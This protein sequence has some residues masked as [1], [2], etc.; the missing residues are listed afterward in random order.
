[1]SQV[2]NIRG[3][4][5][6]TKCM[7][8]W[9]L[10]SCVVPVLIRFFLAVIVRVTML[11]RNTLYIHYFLGKGVPF[12]FSPAFPMQRLPFLEITVVVS[13]S[14]YWVPAVCLHVH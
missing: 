5:L 10:N 14:V 4:G 8:G 3:H 12:V 9:V 1:M 6:G 13:G 11:F 2:L 7:I